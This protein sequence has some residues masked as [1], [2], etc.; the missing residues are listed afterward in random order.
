M[1]KRKRYIAIP[2]ILS[3]YRRYAIIPIHTHG[4]T[5][6]LISVSFR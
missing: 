2:C 1:N 4:I 6:F 3:I 5:N